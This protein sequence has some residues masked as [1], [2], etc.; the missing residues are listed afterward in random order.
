MIRQFAAAICV[1][2]AA[3]AQPAA[4]QQALVDE[5][6]VAV[7]VDRVTRF[8]ARTPV[9]AR[10]GALTFLGGLTLSSR[11]PDFGGLSGLR[12]SADGARLTA[13]SDRGMWFR[14]ALSYEDGTLAG[15]SEMTRKSIRGPRGLL[16]GRRGSDT[17][18]LEIEGRSAWV[19]SERVNELL[20][21][22]LDA[23]GRPGDGRRV[24]L[25]PEARKGPY[26]AGFEAIALT[27]TGGLMLVGEKFPDENGNDRGFVVG[28][29]APFAFSVRRID[30]FSPTDLARLPGGGFVLIERR[31][32][33]P[34]SLHVRLRR[35]AEADIRP[36]AVVDGPVLMEATLAQT[37]DNFEGVSAH[38][39]ADGTTVITLV[40]DDNFSALQRTLLLQFGLPDE[41]PLT[42]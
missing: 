17:E 3:F 33:P 21:L 29:K 13:I 25:P 30:D 5:T 4:A 42:R 6:P 20:R 27:K 40:S 14:A 26:N 41:G 34:F 16:P 11:D 15:L 38:R 19:A 8:D 32:R 28:V 9:G 24:E 36:G 10:Y 35:L 22:P 18:A 2:A 23:T 12:L 1:A 31:Y 7:A 37:I 39:R